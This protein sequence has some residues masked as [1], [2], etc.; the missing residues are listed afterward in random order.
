MSDKK[1]PTPL[2]DPY[3]GVA[4]PSEPAPSSAAPSSEVPSSQTPSSEAPPTDAARPILPAAGRP[5]EV[6]EVAVPRKQ[7]SQPLIQRDD[8]E[9]AELRRRKRASRRRKLRRALRYAALAVLGCA[10]IAGAVFGVRLWRD[11]QPIPFFPNNDVATLPDK[12]VL[13]SRTAVRDLERADPD[14]A[15]PALEQARWSKLAADLCGGTDVFADLYASNRED[16]ARTRA[17]HA[18]ERRG[19]T[20]KALACGR[21][22]SSQ[23]GRGRTMVSFTHPAPPERRSSRRRHD[24]DTPPPPPVE[25]PKDLVESVAL[26]PLDRDALPM[27][28][29]FFIER[30]DR[31]G[32]LGTRCAVDRSARFAECDRD[33][34]ASAHLE[35]LPYWVGGTVTA[36]ELFGQN[37]SRKAKNH[38][39]HARVLRTL[40]EE[41]ESNSNVV[42]GIHDNFGFSFVSRLGV[43]DPSFSNATLPTPE[44]LP[45][46]GPAAVNGKLLALIREYEAGWAVVDNLSASG[47][48]LIVVLLALN[49][50]QAIDLMLELRE[51]R[52]SLAELVAEAD[53]SGADKT[54]DNKKTEDKEKKGSRATRD[55]TGVMDASAKRAL[56]KARVERKGKLVRLVLTRE[57]EKDEREAVR[58]MADLVAEQARGA[59]RIVDVLVAGD[60]PED[61]LLHDVGGSQLVELVKHPEDGDRTPPEF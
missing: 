53:K 37:F 38:P 10:V 41:L 1:D 52:D 43:S 12:T 24:D 2:L 7:P 22:L 35:G 36:I 17:A 29:A 30:R 14:F 58:E 55:F 59:A 40:A 20:S 9:A 44:A 61:D 21:T 34:A 6:V 28:S 16:S 42:I 39:D 8:G 33:A 31:T 11:R 23:V 45:E 51:W 50:T 4:P 13:V 15:E 18:I 57:L 49:E 54:A 27:E 25:E 3:A 5:A 19:H 32:L 56:T 47:G 26:Y 48:E 60:R 46:P